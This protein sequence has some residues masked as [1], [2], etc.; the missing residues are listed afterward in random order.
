VDD[1]CA[2]RPLGGLLVDSTPST[3]LNVQ[4]AGQTFRRLFANCRCQ[5]LRA[6][7][8]EAF[9]S[10]ARSSVPIGAPSPEAVIVNGPAVVSLVT[11]GSAIT[12]LA[13]GVISPTSPWM[14][15]SPLN[16]TGPAIETST[17]ATGSGTPSQVTVRLGAMALPAP[18]GTATGDSNWG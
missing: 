14:K 18:I 17:D 2:E 8:G 16:P 3:V 1:R 12:P 6:R 7:F 10:R 15:S 13:S 4:S 5:R 11:I 9:S